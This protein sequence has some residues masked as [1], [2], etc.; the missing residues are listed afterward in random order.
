MLGIFLDN[1]AANDIDENDEMLVRKKRAL[2]GSLTRLLM[3]LIALLALF[4]KI[5]KLGNNDGKTQQ[6]HTY[7]SE[8]N[9]IHKTS[10]V[11]LAPHSGLA[12]PYPVR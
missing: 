12:P 8:H 5:L 4:A 7:I 2:F 6:C 1:S 10:E 11:Y 3:L 9:N